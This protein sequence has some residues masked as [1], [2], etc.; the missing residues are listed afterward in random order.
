[1][2]LLVS[3]AWLHLL[4]MFII[5][6]VSIQRGMVGVGWRWLPIRFLVSVT[7]FKAILDQISGKRKGVGVKT[8][9]PNCISLQA[10]PVNPPQNRDFELKSGGFS[11]GGLT[12]KGPKFLTKVPRP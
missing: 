10:L 1:M 9:G 3:T 4:Q 7:K 8:N 2:G 11:G 6:R 5:S 12:L